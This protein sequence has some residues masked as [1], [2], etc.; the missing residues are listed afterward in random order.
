[1]AIAVV[2]FPL[3]FEVVVMWFV[4]PSEVLFVAALVVAVAAV[5]VVSVAAVVM[6]VDVVAEAV[7]SAVA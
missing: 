4:V 1:M 6:V 7:L 2:H 3:V 5:A